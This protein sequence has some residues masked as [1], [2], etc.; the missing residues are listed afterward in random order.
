MIYSKFFVCF[1]KKKFGYDCIRDYTI[2]SYLEIYAFKRQDIKKKDN[3]DS[4]DKHMRTN[5]D[6]NG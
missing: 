3:L 4:M 2:H 6:G 5:N 1:I